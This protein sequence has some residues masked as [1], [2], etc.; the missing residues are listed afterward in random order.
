MCIKSCTRYLSVHCDI[1]DETVVSANKPC[2]AAAPSFPL[3]RWPNQ[4]CC[5]FQNSTAGGERP[6]W[7]VQ[8]LYNLLW[9]WRGVISMIQL[10]YLGLWYTSCK[11][12]HSLSPSPGTLLNL[13]STLPLSLRWIARW[14]LFL[15]QIPHVHACWP[16]S[17][18]TSE[19]N[20]AHTHRLWGG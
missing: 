19:T 17:S 9:G 1:R 13:F 15:Q 10:S 11:Y 18:H 7:S 6:K 3:C 5:I 14:L 16:H 2:A 20:K 8:E 4:H 12:I